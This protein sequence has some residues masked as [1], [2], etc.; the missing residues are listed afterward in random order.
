M[1][2]IDTTLTNLLVSTSKIVFLSLGCTIDSFLGLRQLED[3]LGD[4]SSLL[5]FNSCL[6]LLQEIYFL[7]KSIGKAASRINVE[8]L[9]SFSGKFFGNNR[10]KCN[11]E[12]PVF[13]SML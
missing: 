3:S 2:P 13:T 8:K 6:K 12:K 10:K 7:W 1:D 11:K 9:A 4:L 5:T